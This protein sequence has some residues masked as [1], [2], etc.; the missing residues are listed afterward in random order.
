MYSPHPIADNI[1]SSVE[2]AAVRV[3]EGN[4]QL[5]TTVRLKASARLTN[6][7]AY[8]LVNGSV[9]VHIMA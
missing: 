8:V 2:T 4:K 5:E 9:R 7:M 3:E 6:S 1:E